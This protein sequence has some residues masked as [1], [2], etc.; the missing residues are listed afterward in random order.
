MCK[1]LVFEM[2]IEIRGGM[3][4][5]PVVNAEGRW[6][7]PEA[8]SLFSLGISASAKPLNQSTYSCCAS[9][10]YPSAAATRMED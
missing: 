8:P 5:G 1:R 9:S 3:S 2:D 4:G 7:Q 6:P 10:R